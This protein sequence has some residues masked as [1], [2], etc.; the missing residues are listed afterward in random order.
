MLAGACDQIME[1]RKQL[2]GAIVTVRELFGEMPDYANELKARLDKYEAQAAEG[3]EGWT[4]HKSELDRVRGMLEETKYWIG[5]TPEGMSPDQLE[6]PVGGLEPSEAQ[7]A[8]ELIVKGVPMQL[9]TKG[10]GLD[11]NVSMRGGTVV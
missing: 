2:E 11:V 3:A 9:S 10:S 5:V 8:R 1:G 6:I 7:K 4:V